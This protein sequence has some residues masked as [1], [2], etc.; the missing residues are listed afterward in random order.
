MS[1]AN[2]SQPASFNRHIHVNGYCYEPNDYAGMLIRD[3]WKRNEANF[4]SLETVARIAAAVGGVFAIGAAFWDPSYPVVKSLAFGAVA[5][6]GGVAYA[7]VAN[8]L[9]DTRDSIL[10]QLAAAQQNFTT[11]KLQ[12]ETS[13]P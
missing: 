11:R 6:I 3:A 5:A 2:C 1:M 4:V 9:H 12:K 8:L 7:K 10:T 13:C